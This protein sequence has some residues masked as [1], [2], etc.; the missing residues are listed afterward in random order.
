VAFFLHT[1]AGHPAPAP[2]SSRIIDS[3]RSIFLWLA[4]CQPP[5]RLSL[6]LERLLTIWARVLW[7]MHHYWPSSG[8]FSSRAASTRSRSSCNQEPGRCRF[9]QWFGNNRS[10]FALQGPASWWCHRYCCQ[11][12]PVVQIHPLLFLD[13]FCFWS[14]H[15]GMRSI[16]PALFS[17]SKGKSANRRMAMVGLG[18]T[19]VAWITCSPAPYDICEE[20]PLPP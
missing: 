12:P 13:N 4:S 17:A 16:A 1:R 3:H 10:P 11:L 9:F 14:R 6:L 2:S 8:I 5:L 18:Q 15:P 7:C 20:L 19:L